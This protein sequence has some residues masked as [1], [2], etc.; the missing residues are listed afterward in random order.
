MKALFQNKTFSL[1]AL[2]LGVA[3]CYAVGASSKSWTASAP[4][5]SETEVSAGYLETGGYEQGYGS[6]S[7]KCCDKPPSK[8]AL[9]KSQ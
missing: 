9:L 7:S 4:L 5:K 2:G 1:L 6:A 3:V 8:N